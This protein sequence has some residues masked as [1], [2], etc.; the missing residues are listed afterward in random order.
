VKAAAPMVP[1]TRAAI[2]SPRLSWVTFLKNDN[3]HSYYGNARSNMQKSRE[4]PP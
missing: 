2:T 4:M 3:Y 1:I